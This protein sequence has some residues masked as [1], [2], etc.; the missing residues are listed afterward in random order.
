[1]HSLTITHDGRL[2]AEMLHQTGLLGNRQQ[3]GLR[4]QD[5]REGRALVRLRGRLG[6]VGGRLSTSQHPLAGGT[7]RGRAGEDDVEVLAV[8]AHHNDLP[9]RYYCSSSGKEQ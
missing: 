6:S 2:L 3:D 5:G 7:V 4:L 9:P 1:M 8:L